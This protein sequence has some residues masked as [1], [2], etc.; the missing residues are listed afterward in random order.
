VAILHWGEI[1]DGCA[2]QLLAIMSLPPPFAPPA[3]WQHF[4]APYQDGQRAE[5]AGFGFGVGQALLRPVRAG[6]RRELGLK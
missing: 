1:R 4:G 5:R 6:T 2:Q 3:L